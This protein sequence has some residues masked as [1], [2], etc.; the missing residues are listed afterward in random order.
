ML[1][2]N[3]PRF[4]FLACATPALLSAY[5][6][7]QSQVGPAFQR[8]TVVE[9][10]ILPDHSGLKPPIF[11][12]PWDSMNGTR[13]AQFGGDFLTPRIDMHRCSQSIMTITPIGLSISTRASA[14]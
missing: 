2:T 5:V 12:E 1:T 14:I 6:M 8:S 4:V 11:Y 7:A 10:Y 9:D 3:Q 13:R